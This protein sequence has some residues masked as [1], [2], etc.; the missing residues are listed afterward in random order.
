[1]HPSSFHTLGLFCTLPCPLSQNKRVRVRRE[2]TPSTSHSVANARFF[3]FQPRACL[4]LVRLIDVLADSPRP[5]DAVMRARRGASRCGKL[6]ERLGMVQSEAA[7]WSI[8]TE[9]TLGIQPL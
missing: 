1:M 2:D 9:T 7:R 4:T 3:A 5:R 6:S 8:T